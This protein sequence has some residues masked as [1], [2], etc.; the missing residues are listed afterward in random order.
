MSGRRSKRVR[1]RYSC[2]NSS[3]ITFGS[4]KPANLAKNN[5]AVPN[6]T[7]YLAIYSQNAQNQFIGEGSNVIAVTV[8]S[9]GPATT[10]NIK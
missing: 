4:C 1:T 9:P 8:V 5:G 7:Y 3:R 6:G 10:F 2:C